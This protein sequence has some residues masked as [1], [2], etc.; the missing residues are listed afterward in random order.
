MAL[1]I[2]NNSKNNLAISNEG[3][4]TQ[5]DLWSGRFITWAES[6]P[7]GDTWAVPGSALQKESKNSLS[8]SNEAKN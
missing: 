3:K 4:P 5:P 2:S 8:I 1:S 6:G 7:A